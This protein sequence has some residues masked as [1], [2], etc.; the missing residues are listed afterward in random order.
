MSDP[1][2][3]L[4]KTLSPSDPQ[5]PVPASSSPFTIGIVAT[6]NKDGTVTANVNA[7]TTAATVYWANAFVPKVGQKIIVSATSQGVLYATGVV[8]SSTELP[9]L[10]TAYPVGKIWTSTDPANPATLLGFGTW[11]AFGAGQTLIGAGTSD[12]TYAGGATGGHST[13]TISAS[14]L[15]SASPWPLPN[16]QHDHGASDGTNNLIEGGTVGTGAGI[17]LGGSAYVRGRTD[18][19]L[20]YVSMGTNSSGGTALPT[21]PPYIV[22]Y[23]WKRTA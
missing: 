1:L 6:V 3:D 22:V 11:T 10:M 4:A 19:W 13:F 16:L 5:T 21:V 12:A 17:A 8:T 9:P 20:A 14:Y 23:F 15:P 18:K 2:A 7:A